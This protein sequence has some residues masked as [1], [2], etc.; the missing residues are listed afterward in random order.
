MRMKKE[1]KILLIWIVVGAGMISEALIFRFLLIAPY[2]ALLEELNVNENWYLF[3]IG[4]VFLKGF[5]WLGIDLVILGSFLMVLVKI[6]P[7]IFKP[8]KTGLNYRRIT[9][10]LIISLIWMI[11]FY[12]LV[13]PPFWINVIIAAGFFALIAC[14][15]AYRT[16]KL[17][18]ISRILSGNKK[19]IAIFSI[20]LIGLSLYLFAPTS[21]QPTNLASDKGDF[22][23]QNGKIYDAKTGKELRLM[24]WD[25]HWVHFNGPG[26]AWDSSAK[27]ERFNLSTIRQDLI[28]ASQA[29]NFIRIC[30]NWFEIEEKE[31]EYNYSILDYV[32]DLIE[33]DEEIE[34]LHV[35]LEIGPIKTSKVWVQASL[36]EWFPYRI[37]L[38]DP[39]FLDSVKPFIKKTVER[40]KDEE[41]LFA[42]QLEN[43]P[44]LMTHTVT[45]PDEDYQIT[46]DVYFYLCW[47]NDYVKSLDPKHFTA[48]NYFANNLNTQT[49]IAP[50]DIILYDYYGTIEN[51][52]DLETFAKRNSQYVKGNTAFGVAEL[53]LNDWQTKITEEDLEDEY[54]A[55]INSGMTVILWSEL[56]VPYSWDASAISYTNERTYKY[57]KVQELF[58]E[59]QDENI[60]VLFIQTWFDWLNVLIFASGLI[61][62]IIVYVL[63]TRRLNNIGTKESRSP[64]E[65]SC[66]IILFV[67]F[68]AIV[69][70]QTYISNFMFLGFGICAINLTL[71]S[72]IIKQYYFGSEKDE[73]AHGWLKSFKIAFI[74]GLP[75][76]IISILAFY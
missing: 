5:L 72:L 44:D 37:D 45:D 34:E 55:C 67:F 6:D 56:H 75:V 13:N 63:L 1:N 39:N 38:Q 17:P 14:F 9:I 10:I 32:F 65:F 21:F 54:E 12:T 68:P 58:E 7:N 70:I 74:G 53:Q 49:K 33:N 11:I 27:M 31:G 26:E 51:T 20:I 66:L 18:K 42:Y 46:G 61:G 41:C 16:N 4:M 60:D 25:Y 28:W 52:P 15:T 43:E 22:Y 76:F 59:F 40:Y 47:L 50:V 36:P 30:A 71:G 64:A 35:L 48:V 73:I 2:R 69:F 3:A 29:G 57:Y 23:I 24:G 8:I 19:F 62:T